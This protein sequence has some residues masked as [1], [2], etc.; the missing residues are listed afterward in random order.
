MPSAASIVARS[1]P[2]HVIGIDNHLP[3]HLRTDMKHFRER[4][5][6]HAIIMGR[7]TFDSIGKPLPGR[8]NI[9]LSREEIT[10]GDNLKWAPD[11][12]TALLMSDV[13]SIC[14][15]KKRFYVIGGERIY[16]EFLDYINEVWLTEVFCGRLNGDAKFDYK[17]D[18]T[19]WR[20]ILEREFIQSEYDDHP[21]RISLLVRRKPI[22]RQ[23]FIDDFRNSETDVIAKLEE[24]QSAY[25]A[26][27][28]FREGD[29]EQLTLFPE[30]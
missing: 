20:T 1:H 17:F 25:G 5:S 6:G 14:K 7:R 9:V 26:S 3:W 2:D 18:S 12:S 27:E 24:W 4:T 15:L 13:Y 28:E 10:E 30:G 11:V 19:E 8:L 29:L 22:H 23:R 16:S 21:F